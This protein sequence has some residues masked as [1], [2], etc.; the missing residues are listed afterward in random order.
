MPAA[1]AAGL[2]TVTACGSGSSALPATVSSVTATNPVIGKLTT[3][4]ISGSNLS[5]SISPVTTGCTGLVA[6]SSASTT[7]KEF[8]CT[9]NAPLV[10]VT[11]NYGAQTPY[12]TNLNVRHIASV[13]ADTPVQGWLTTFTVTGDQLPATITPIALACS[14]TSVIAS[15]SMTTRQFTCTPSAPNVEISIDF[16]AASPFQTI[17][18]AAAAPS[19]NAVTSSGI[20][21]GKLTTFSIQGSN[22]SAAVNPSATGCSTLVNTASSSSALREFTCTPDGTSVGVTINFGGGTLYTTSLA[23]PLPQVTFV[24]TLGLVVVELYPDK[25]PASVKNFLSYVDNGFYT[26]TIFHRVVPGFVTQGGGFVSDVTNTIAQKANSTAPIVL[27][28]NNGLSNLKYSVAMARTFAPDSATSQ[29]YFNA[30]N[31]S[32]SLDYKASSAGANGYAVFGKAISGTNV[33][34]SMNA[35]ANATLSSGAYSGYQNVPTTALVL[36]SAARTQ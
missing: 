35:V 24:T 5:S 17:I 8:T 36:Q 1:L 18:S 10:G 25:A 32:A 2:L 21:Y 19:V 20:S 23:V 6:I 15:S 29:F 13:T 14:G 28:S 4:T 34:D 31:N 22:L 30:A 26:N 33:L 27:E 3:I 11:V 9:P 16:G 12:A 7:S